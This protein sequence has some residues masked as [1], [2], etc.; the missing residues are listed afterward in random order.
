MFS[1]LEIKFL[2]GSDTFFGKE[3]STFFVFE[4]VSP[5]ELDSK[6]GLP[7]NIAYKM[8]PKAQISDDNPYGCL[9]M[10]SLHN[11]YGDI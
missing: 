8:H 1:I 7:V 11:N 5:I 2:A 10:I 6:G 4:K 3:K 9:K